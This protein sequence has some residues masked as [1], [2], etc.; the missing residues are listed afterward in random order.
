MSES[1][2]QEYLISYIASDPLLLRPSHLNEPS[3]HSDPSPLMQPL[4][5][6][7]ILISSQ[8]KLLRSVYSPQLIESLI[9]PQSSA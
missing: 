8:P 4:A 6:S 2:I 9:N 1:A 7:I 5:E 3:I